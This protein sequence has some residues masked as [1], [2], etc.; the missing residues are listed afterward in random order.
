MGRCKMR[1]SITAKIIVCNI[2]SNPILPLTLICIEIQ[3]LTLY[4]GLIDLLCGCFC[5]FALFA[6]R[7]LSSNRTYCG[8]LTATNVQTQKSLT[9]ARCVCLSTLTDSSLSLKSFCRV[10]IEDV[11]ALCRWLTSRSLCLQTRRRRRLRR[12][13]R[14]V[15]LLDDE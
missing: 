13:L 8:I 7:I 10:L 14:D 3:T 5:I 15:Y 11:L 2:N 6:F 4:L 9:Y 12:L 1:N